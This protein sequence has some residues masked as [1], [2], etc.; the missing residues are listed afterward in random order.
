M[1]AFDSVNKQNLASLNQEV[2]IV[3][4]CSTK[5]E[6]LE[7][8]DSLIRNDF[9]HISNLQI[10][11]HKENKWLAEARNTGVRNAT[12]KY[13]CCLDPDDTIEPDYL[14][15]S[16]LVLES[17]SCS[18]VYPGLKRF[19]HSNTT[20][21]PPDFDAKKFFFDNFSVSSSVFKRLAWDDVNGQRH[22][23]ISPNVKMYE[24]WD[25][26]IRL[27]AK[28]HFGL[29][30][31]EHLFNYRQ[32]FNSTMTRNWKNHLASSYLVYRKN[33]FNL[34]RVKKA[35]V[36]FLAEKKKWKRS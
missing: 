4:D 9:L 35:D 13:I 6:T 22:W 32:S 11:H 10:I 24:D 36:N 29:P 3:N 34:L 31:K 8:L 26:L 21:F 2:I 20:E 16:I 1:K 19:G 5:K 25:F 28:G 17:H 27:M 30:V 15:K 14:I 7:Y 18:W 12:G 23:N 33:L